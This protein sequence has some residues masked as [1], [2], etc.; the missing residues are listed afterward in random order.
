MI[1]KN[2]TRPR[3]KMN[4]IASMALAIAL[5]GWLVLKAD[6]AGQTKE[7][8]S[9]PVY[10]STGELA[11]PKG[12]RSWIFAGTNLS[13]VYKSELPGGQ[14][15]QEREEKN[16]GSFH[17]VYINPEAY[18][19]FQ[20]TRKFPDQTMLVM[21]VFSAG[22]KDKTG[23]LTGG[24]FE[25][26][27]VALEVAVKDTKR[28]GGGVPWAYYDF[29]IGKNTRPADSA[30]AFPDKKCYDCHLKHAGVD[31]VWVQFYPTLRDEE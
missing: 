1:L 27:R 31:N 6:S 28:P 26:K 25:D 17:N 21:E 30:K 23:F 9:R 11:L 20:K 29:K 24:R 2:L 15:R 22:T 7:N 4:A 16:P 3:I 10:T 19:E 12:Y 18:R 13:P 14:A 8:V 5:G